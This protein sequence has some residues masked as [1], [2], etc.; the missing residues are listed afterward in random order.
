M[1]LI[2]TRQA[3]KRLGLHPATLA[4]YIEVGRLPA[5]TILDVGTRKLHGWTE[6]KIERARALLPKIANGRK[7][8]H[9]KKQLAISN[10]QLAKSRSKAKKKPQPRAA[11]LL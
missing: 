2:S 3:A 4:H 5:P 8:R 11:V 9:L 6:E 1:K 7:M 10:E